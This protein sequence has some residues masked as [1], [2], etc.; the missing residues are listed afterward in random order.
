MKKTLLTCL[1]VWAT[2]IAIARNDANSV[3]QKT[4]VAGRAYGNQP[5]NATQFD[6]PMDVFQI[7]IDSEN[8]TALLV[9]REINRYGRYAGGGKLGLFNCTTGLFQW[10]TPIRDFDIQ[11]TKNT[12]VYNGGAKVFNLADGK[13]IVV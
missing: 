10:E 3:S 6:L 8:N 7:N 1:S 13:E 2:F 9:L 4:V 12:V 11:K 5:V